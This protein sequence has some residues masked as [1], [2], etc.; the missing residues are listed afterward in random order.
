MQIIDIADNAVMLP[1]AGAIAAWLIAGRAWKMAVCWCVLFSLGLSI[2]ALSKILFLGWAAGIPSLDFKALSGHALRATVVMPVLLYVSLQGA[3]LWWRAAGVI[4]GVACSLCI[5]VL[6]VSL[7][8][9]T[10]SEVVASSMLGIL[11]GAGFM[12]IAAMLPA[13]RASVWA[14]TLGLSAFVVIFSLKP[15]SMNHRLVDV[16]LYLSDRQHPYSW[17]QR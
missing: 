12:R 13:P 11:L 16:A 5:G 14:I 4:F 9:H 7:G 10:T 3:P 15:S 17:S 8:F 6:L 1:L 2:V